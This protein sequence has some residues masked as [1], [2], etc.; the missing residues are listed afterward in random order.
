VTIVRDEECF[1]ADDDVKQIAAGERKSPSLELRTSLQKWVNRSRLLVRGYLA[2]GPDTDFYMQAVL[3]ERY[4]K[5]FLQSRARIIICGVGVVLAE[6][7]KL[8]K[9]RATVQTSIKKPVTEPHI[10]DGRIAWR[11]ND[12]NPAADSRCTNARLGNKVFP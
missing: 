1:A 5:T 8:A 11:A 3:R 12:L 10:D 6:I 4:L 2:R 7:G 9:R